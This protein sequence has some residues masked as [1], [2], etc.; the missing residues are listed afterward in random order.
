MIYFL[1][2]NDYQL[3][4]AQ[5]HLAQLRAIG[6]AAS[7]IEVPHALNAQD[8]GAGFEGVISLESPLTSRGWMAAWPRYFASARQV[9]RKIAPQAGDTLFFYTEFELLNHLIARRFKAAGARAILL[10]D[11]GFGTYLPFSIEAGEPLGTKERVIAAMTRLLPGLRGTVFHKVN[12]QV[13]PWLPDSAID[14]VAMYREVRIV[15]SIPTVLMHD[16]ERPRIETRQGKAIFMNER[17]YDVYQT[18]EQ[19]FRGL[20][21]ILGALT[22]GFPSVSFKFHPREQEE[23]TSAIRALL[24]SRFP[25]VR[26]IE[27]RQSME[28]LLAVERPEVLASYFSTTL[29]NLGDCGVQPMYLYHLF[30]DLATQKIFRQTTALLKQWHYRFVDGFADVRT[31]YR[32]GLDTPGSRARTTIC[33]LAAGRP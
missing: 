7:L 10:E 14:A 27:E 8:R 11:G 17:M 22:A 23:W 9:V 30:E 28:H 24:A 6:V 33:Q 25:S 32:S 5:R 4:D 21:V 31:G 15:R 3:V 16:V 12:D 20:D 1:V 13:F 19:Y 18:R 2:N 29:L 26:I